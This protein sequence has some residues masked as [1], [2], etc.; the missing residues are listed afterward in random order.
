MT[1]IF[2]VVDVF[3]R[4]KRF[5]KIGDSISVNYEGFFEGNIGAS[6]VT[7]SFRSGQNSADQRIDPANR[8]LPA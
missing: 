8:L 3:V 1:N 7:G 4:V 5:H 2:K 6:C